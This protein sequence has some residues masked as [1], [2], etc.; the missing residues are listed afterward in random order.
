MTKNRTPTPVYLDHGMHSGLEVKRLKRWNFVMKNLDPK[1]FYSVWNQR[2]CLFQLF[3]IHL[4]T[5]MYVMGLRPLE[6]FLLSQCGY[7]LWTSESDVYRRQILTSKVDPRAVRVN[8]FSANHD[9]NCFHFTMISYNGLRSKLIVNQQEWQMSQIK[10][11]RLIFTHP[12]LW[13]VVLWH[14]FGQIRWKF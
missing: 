4:N 2:K 10:Q 14:N 13:V 7:L 12:N 8:P 6:I 1:C 9:Y 3:P 5:Y 11:I